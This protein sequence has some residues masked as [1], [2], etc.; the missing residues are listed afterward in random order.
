MKAAITEIIGDYPPPA[1]IM[2]SAIRQL[3]FNISKDEGLGRIDETLK[4]G[5]PAYLCASGSTVRISWKPANPERV[6]LYFNCQTKLMSTFREIFPEAFEF[7]GNR[8]IRL[9]LSGSVPEEELRLCLS[10][11]LRYHRIKHLPLLGA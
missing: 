8:E 1:K 3:I 10:M 4:W 2:F 6:S 9:P 7:H 5:E 11:A